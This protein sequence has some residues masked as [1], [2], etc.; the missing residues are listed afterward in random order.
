MSGELGALVPTAHAAVPKRGSRTKHGAR[1]GHVVLQLKVTLRHVRPPVWRRI[2]VS[3]DTPL[4]RLHDILQEAMGWTDSHLHAFAHGTTVYMADDPDMASGLAFI[5]E[6]GVPI[7]SLL[8]EPKDRLR[9]DYDFG[10]GWEHD[11]VVEKVLAPSAATRVP[12]VLAG[13]RACPPEDVGGVHGYEMFLEILADPAHPEHAEMREWSG[14]DGDPESF[15]LEDA[16]A[17]VAKAGGL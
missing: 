5:E 17:R 13:R 10:D 9:Y 1:P 11:V 2:L 14:G 7:G 3:S 4:E 8:V 6:R 16:D 12:A 15:D